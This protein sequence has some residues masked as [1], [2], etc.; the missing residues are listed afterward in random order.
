MDS[1]RLKLAL[2]WPKKVLIELT[3]TTVIIQSF[4]QITVRQEGTSETAMWP[5]QQE[6]TQSNCKMDENLNNYQKKA[7]L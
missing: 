6:T 7:L 2:L 3:S 5:S 1:S 4:I